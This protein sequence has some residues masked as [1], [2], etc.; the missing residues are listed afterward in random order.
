MAHDDRQRRPHRLWK[1]LKK[2]RLRSPLFFKTR[3]PGLLP[4]SGDG[5][6]FVPTNGVGLGHM[7]RLLAIARRL[8]ELDPGREIVFC[9][10]SSALIILRR[11]GFLAYHLP[12][13]RDYPDSVES[14]RWNLVLSH[15]LRSVLSMH[16]PRL[17]V[18]DGVSLYRG[19]R[20]AVREAEGGVEGP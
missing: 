10:S 15:H 16:R 7:T 20:R 13:M 3:T 6:L 11:E 9:T 14:R 5:V 8:R 19:L 17:V 12:S 2:V 1:R 18:F 4:G